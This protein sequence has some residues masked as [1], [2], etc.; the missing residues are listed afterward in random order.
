M[1]RRK[2][3]Y[4]FVIF[5]ISIYGISFLNS[6]CN[7]PHIQTNLLSQIYEPPYIRDDL[8][9]VNE[10]VNYLIAETHNTNKKIYIAIDSEIFSQELLNRSKLPECVD[11][12]PA[13]IGANIKDTRDGFPSQAFLADYI[14]ISPALYNNQAVIS[15]LTRIIE[16]Q[17]DDYYQLVQQN[18]ITDNVPVRIYKKD[19]AITKSYVDVLQHRLKEIYPDN[20]FVYH[21]NYFIALVNINAAKNLEYY[22]WLN[23]YILTKSAEENIQIF[24]Q[25]DKQF[26][27]IEFTVTNW[28]PDCSIQIKNDDVIV[29]DELISENG[30]TKYRFDVTEVGNL[31][32]SI[33]SPYEQ[34]I[35]LY[36]GELK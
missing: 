28:Y 17:R 20:T 21:P 8:E 15:E 26:K 33:S 16:N 12:V 22:S 14:I 29:Y 2:L 19:K 35:N 6:F 10:M 27:E 36:N 34:S 18:V 13:I 4:I 25:L 31:K 23:G 7:E 5:I 30:D 3:Q 24:Y 9:T 32:I 1:K 11:A